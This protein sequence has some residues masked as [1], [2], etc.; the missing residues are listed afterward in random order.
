MDRA[1]AM[2]WR[3]SRRDHA[4]GHSRRS[5]SR[6]GTLGFCALEGR[7]LYVSGTDLQGGSSKSCVVLPDRVQGQFAP[8]R[9]KRVSILRAGGKP[10]RLLGAVKDNSSLGFEMPYV[11]DTPLPTIAH[12]NLILREAR[13]AGSEDIV[14]N[15]GSRPTMDIERAD[16][17]GPRGAVQRSCTCPYPVLRRGR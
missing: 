6:L 10:E 14:P 12:T 2:Q 13:N 17:R 8:S 11:R 5:S 1:I 4:F 3:K 16:P 7:E 9:Y 15:R